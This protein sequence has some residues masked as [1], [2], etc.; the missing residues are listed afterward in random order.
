MNSVPLN[1]N[2]SALN[3]QRRLGVSAQSLTKSFERLSSGLRIHRASDD[4]AGLSIAASLDTDVRILNQAIRNINDGISYLTIAN[5]ATGQLKEILFRVRELATQSSN[6]TL[7]DA[8]RQ[9]LDEEVQALIVE[10]NRIIGVTR[11]NGR[12][13]FAS[14]EHQLSIQAGYGVH[15]AITVDIGGD[16]TS[17]GLA[18]A[19]SIAIGF[20]QVGITS[21][22]LD[23]DGARDLVSVGVNTVNV[24]LGNGD[25]TFQAALTFATGNGSSAVIIDDFDGDGAKDL[26]TADA[27]TVS[28]LLGNGDGTF[29][30]ASSLPSGN[31]QFSLTSGDFDGDGNRDIAAPSYQTNEI[32]VYYGN[33]DGTFSAPQT[34]ATGGFPDGIAT[35]DLNADGALDLVTA[36]QAGNTVSV[37]L[38]NGNGT[39][40]ARVGYT[41]GSFS[42]DVAIGD[43][44]GDGT[45]DLVSA[46]FASSTLSV[47]RGNGDGTFQPRQTYQTGSLPSSVKIADINRD[48]TLDLITTDSGDGTVST[49]IGSGDGTFQA[50]TIYAAGSGARSVTASDLNGDGALDIA[51]ANNSGN[52]IS[53]LL[54]TVSSTTAS[55]HPLSG[56]SVATQYAGLDAQSTVDGFLD[57]VNAVVSLIGSAVSRFE[58]AENVLDVERESYAAA[59]SRIIDADVAEES[60]SLVRATIIQE[61]GVAVLTQAGRAP[62]LTLAL[63]GA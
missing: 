40:Q 33:G 27:V 19:Q 20:P 44:D 23:G 21:A 48:G 43:L 9:P 58:V 57:E 37:L 14:T 49:F 16:A 24:F 30:A 38:G 61:A 18:A 29:Q 63:L 55:I 5:G 31:F 7:S 51:T 59:R 39:F 32:N 4:A 22:D 52:S 25:G 42:Y 54:A 46:D 1:T 53:V 6:G 12:Q 26:A 10:Y 34:L 60:A 35:V 11:F 36:D 47:L 62:E 8:E 41:V 15:G 2:V 3:A 28:I 13:I 17:T 50:R 45:L 56:I